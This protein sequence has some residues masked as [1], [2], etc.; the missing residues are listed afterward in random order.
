MVLSLFVASIP[1][2]EALSTFLFKQA[3]RWLIKEAE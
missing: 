3:L 2:I 1:V